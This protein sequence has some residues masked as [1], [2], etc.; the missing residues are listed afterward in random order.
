VQYQP[1]RSVTHCFYTHLYMY[2]YIFHVVALL[3]GVQV[4]KPCVI[5]NAALIIRGLQTTPT[6][7]FIKFL[8]YHHQ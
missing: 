2:I 4:A 7:S 6:P 1:H 8:V 3:L 5:T